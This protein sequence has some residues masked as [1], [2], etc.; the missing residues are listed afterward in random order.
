MHKMDQ[1][2][3]PREGRK[4]QKSE[5]E[6]EERSTSEKPSCKI[7]CHSRVDA[8]LCLPL[9]IY[10]SQYISGEM[11]L[12]VCVCVCVSGQFEVEGV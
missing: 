5:R 7:S 3:S 1:V 10:V 8:G 2:E 12:Y 11:E 6:R 9:W 4:H